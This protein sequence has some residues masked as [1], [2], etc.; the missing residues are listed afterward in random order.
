MRRTL[1][2]RAPV[3]TPIAELK[4]QFEVQRY[5][6]YLLAGLNPRKLTF[7]MSKTILPPCHIIFCTS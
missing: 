5:W 6:V 3:M 2:S 7:S 4:V 1:L